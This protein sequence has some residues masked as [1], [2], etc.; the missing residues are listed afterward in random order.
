MASTPVPAGEPPVPGAQWDEVHRRWERWDA[1]AQAWRVV[2]DPGDG[3]DPA[4]ESD[5]P[6]TLVRVLTHETE[7]IP[8]ELR[9]AMPEHQVVRV[10]EPDE[11]PP[12]A[13][14]N[15]V[16]GRWER[17]D[18]GAGAWV[19]AAVDPKAAPSGTTADDA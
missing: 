14:W 19:E 18:D 1:E 10:P 9:H 2:G 13:Q 11:G 5:L 8:D 17:W 3:V 15:E 16:R 6:A 7:D 4:D 12:G